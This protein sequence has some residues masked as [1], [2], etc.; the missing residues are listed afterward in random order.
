MLLVAAAL[1]G[2]GS[3]AAGGTR[4]APPAKAKA[5]APRPG[6]QAGVRAALD[7]LPRIAHAQSQLVTGDAQTATCAYRAGGERLTVEIQSVPQAYLVYETA[8]VHQVQANVGR[9]DTAPA[10]S[11]PKQVDDVGVLAS[12]IPS[13]RQLIT[14][15]AT[16]RRGGAF[17][18]VTMLHRAHG[19][20]KDLAVA[21]RVARAVLRTAPRGPD[22]AAPSG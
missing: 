8:S 20:P 1:A 13:E 17:V 22:P 19:A 4:P 21:R 9:S 12:W 7:R 18:R 11:Y 15:N 3:D 10:N 14:T 2:C 16:R 6:C 5:Q